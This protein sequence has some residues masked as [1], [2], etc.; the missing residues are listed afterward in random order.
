MALNRGFSIFCLVLIAALAPSIGHAQPYTKA[1]LNS[2]IGVNFPDNRTFGISPL[3]RTIADNIVNSIMPT[4]PVTSGDLACYSGTNGLLADCG[5]TIARSQIPNTGVTP[6]SYTNSNVT[7]GSD[8]R[9]TSATNGLAS[10]IFVLPAA[11]TSGSGSNT[12]GT[13]SASSPTL[14]LAVAIDFAN[15]QGIRINHA[16]AAFALNPP[17]AASVTPTGTMGSTTYTYTIASLS[18][19]GG[20]GQSIANVSTSTGNASLS[21]TNYNALSWTGATGTAPAAYAI[22]GNQ[23]GS[24]ALIGIVPGTQTTF[25]DAGI[26]SISAPDWLPT[27]PQTGASLANWLITTISSGAGTT[28]LTLAASA[29]TAATAQFVVHDDTAN[30]QSAISTAQSTGNALYIPPGSYRVTSPVTISSRIKIF[31]AGYK[32]DAGGGYA[33]HGVGQ[34]SGFLGSVLVFDIF[35]KIVATTNY[36]V[37]IYDLQI[38]Y[39]IAEISGATALTIQAVAGAGNAN[40]QSVIRGVMI[41][42]HWYAVSMTNALDFIID[43][44]QFLYGFGGGVLANA[45]NYPSY[46]QAIVSNNLFWGN[47]AINALTNQYQFHIQVQAG[48]DLR[49]IGNKLDAGGPNTNAIAL[50]GRNSGTQNLEPTTINSNS[51]EGA[52]NCITFSTANSSFT[53][54]QIEIT[55]NQMWCGGKTL[56]VNTM[57]TGQYVLAMTITGNS[58]TVNGGASVS[59][60][61][62]D[63]VKNA[64]ITGNVFGCSGG[65]TTSTGIN[66]GSHTTGI[67]VQ[68]NS[69][70][71]GYTTKVNNAGTGNT[72]GGGSS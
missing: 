61:Q 50:L 51:I 16:G 14:S 38:T 31:G 60:L 63:S 30:L 23:A 18:A 27:T 35:A 37:Q 15:G 1:Q 66:L 11:T 3:E 32:G 56:I 41:T 7:I 49:I 24:L 69:Y 13:I 17:T 42:G 48:G 71:A 22:Y 64:V 34:S 70:D 5:P 21:A 55:G 72:V 12:T 39:P 65:C 46:N 25:N 67:N 57:G 54:S 68:S 44:N 43:G 62:L 47:G 28:T 45:P 10:S 52:Q 29:T 20:V 40:T 33:G 58:L 19:T 2:Q 59:N 9:I 6:G 53:A 36:A 26:G 4:A 8:G